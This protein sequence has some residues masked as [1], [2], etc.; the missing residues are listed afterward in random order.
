MKYNANILQIIDKNIAEGSLLIAIKD[1]HLAVYY[2]ASEEFI[3]NYLEKLPIETEIDLWLVWGQGKIIKNNG[4]KY[5]NDINKCGGH[6]EGRIIN[7]FT[8]DEFTLDCGLLVD[9]EDEGRPNFQVGDFVK[10]SGTY[11]IYFQGTEWTR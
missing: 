7:V 6:F 2:Q 4:F 3:T 5:P 1:I 10:T 9:V 8:E 11:K